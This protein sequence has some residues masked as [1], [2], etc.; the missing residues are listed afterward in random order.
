MNVLNQMSVLKL[1]QS[2]QQIA[3][4]M[5]QAI[6][7]N[8]QNAFLTN[9]KTVGSKLGMTKIPLLPIRKLPEVSSS[10]DKLVMFY[11][12]WR[13]LESFSGGF[14]ANMFTGMSSQILGEKFGI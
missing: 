1:I 12:Y 5:Y 8:Y 10:A 3:Y 6:P 9:Q 4:K 7:G 2:L 11:G 14:G 13:H